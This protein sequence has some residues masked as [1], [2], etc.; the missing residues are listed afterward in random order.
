MHRQ[1]PRGFRDVPIALLID[2]LDMLPPDPVGTHRVLRRRRKLP[3]PAQ[4]RR[5]DIIRIG[6]L[7]QIIRRP[8]LHRRHRRRDRPVSGQHDD[9]RI[10]PPLPQRLDHVKPVP[11]LQ[12][13]INDGISR[14]IG[15]RR[16]D[17]RLDTFRSRHR[18]PALFHRPL[19]P[20]KERLVVIDQKKRIVR[21]DLALRTLAHA[22]ATSIHRLSPSHIYSNLRRPT[23]FG[24]VEVRTS[25]P[26][27]QD[28]FTERRVRLRTLTSL[29]WIAI[30]GQAV[31][32]VIATRFFGLQIDVGLCSVV[33]GVSVL[34]NVIAAAV[35][36]P[37]HLLDER[38]TAW[39]LVFDLW[40]L[41]GLLALTG[42]L[43]NPF[44]LLIIAPVTIGATVLPLRLIV[45]I[46][47]MASVLVTALRFMFAPLV[48]ADGTVAAM[49]DIFVNGL[50]VSILIGIVFLSVYAG[51][52]TAEIEQLAHALEATR[53]ALSREQ[54]LT[55]LG[56]VVAATAHELGTPL[57]TIK[58]ASAE[59]E[60]DLADQPELAAD[61]RL[62]REQADRCRDILQSMGRAGKS[63]RLTRI[64]PLTE[65]L[66]EAAE[67][68]VSRGKT[69]VIE[70]AASGQPMME[71]SP[72]IIHGIRNLVQNA[73]DFADQSVSIESSWTDE[74]IT[75]L[76]SDDGPGF[77]PH[78]IPRLG[79][80]LMHRRRARRRGGYEGMGLG[81]FIAKTLLERTGA[82][83]SFLNA[84]DAGG[85]IV[86]IRWD[87]AT[88]SS[89]SDGRAPLGENVQIA[90]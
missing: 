79:E 43:H 68:H 24:P 85:A 46:A 72:E 81:L 77:P 84:G 89:D 10:L 38:E 47:A 59:L 20:A 75:V 78:I 82:E 67:P 65:I 45:V 35:Y 15:L 23:A 30:A 54:K 28:K 88:I 32:V 14:R 5:R 80:P 25:M 64:A 22:N 2:P 66:R 44:S 34:A 73:V 37:S 16:D 55:D 61:A 60:D 36:D 48:L 31:A 90:E 40:Q 21:A 19:Q 39:A 9:P 62:I 7:R 8:D 6:R 17:A 69:V 42:G 18:E 74:T 27:D 57:A 56:G 49:P 52:V 1:P 11:I 12:T 41:Y 76:I 50:W 71:R 26:T 29:R 33:I 83:L 53:L 4:K 58:L 86:E 51:R 63:D 13:Q 87:R 70:Q 3:A